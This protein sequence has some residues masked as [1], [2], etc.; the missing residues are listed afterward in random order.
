MSGQLLQ[1]INILGN[2]T[3]KEIN[4]SSLSAGFYFVKVNSNTGETI[5]KIVKE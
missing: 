1:Q 4:M 2:S 5:Q 3:Y